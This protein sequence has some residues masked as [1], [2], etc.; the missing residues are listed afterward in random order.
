MQQH[1]S[2]VTVDK[3]VSLIK[4]NAYLTKIDLKSAYS[5]VTLHYYWSCMAFLVI[6]LS[7]ICMTL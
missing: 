1:Y 2:Q 7:Q 6:K 3:A 4:S 5:S